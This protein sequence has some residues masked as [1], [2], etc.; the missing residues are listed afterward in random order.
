MTPLRQRMLEDMSIRNLAENTQLSYLQQVSLYAK[1]FRRSPEELGPEQ[2]RAY[3]VH[4]TKTRK[5]TPASVDIATA[6]LRFLYKVTLKREPWTVPD[7]YPFGEHRVVPL[8][9]GETV[10]W[11]VEAQPA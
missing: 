3:Q 2:V 5:L 10:T 9:A 8:R 11:R 1:H 7:A 4:L 6:A